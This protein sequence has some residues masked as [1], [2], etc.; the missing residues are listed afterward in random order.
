MNLVTKRMLFAD[1][2]I[3]ES[4][5]ILGIR[6]KTPCTFNWPWRRELD[7]NQLEGIQYE[8]KGARGSD[9]VLLYSLFLLLY[10]LLQMSD[11]DCDCKVL[12]TAD[13][14]VT[15]PCVTSRWE[16]TM[17]AV[18]DARRAE[19]VQWCDYCLSIL[20][21]YFNYFVGYCHC[22]RTRSCSSGWYSLQ[23]ETNRLLH[24]RGYISTKQNACLYWVVNK[25]SCLSAL[26]AHVV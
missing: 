11:Q 3:I 22:C 21:Y 19:T 6:N 10:K 12:L 4:V 17:Q 24:H 14:R 9:P 16:N 15:I 8:W 20:H 26:A 13:L 2:S 18:V 7:L 1:Q 23:N 5:M 25:A